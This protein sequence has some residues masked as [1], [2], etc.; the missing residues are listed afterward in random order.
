MGFTRRTF[1]P[2]GKTVLITAAVVPPTGVQVSTFYPSNDGGQAYRIHNNSTVTV[3]VGWG[4]D[5]ATA[6]T[7]AAFPIAGTPSLAVVIPPNDVETFTIGKDQFFS[8]STL[9]STGSVYVVPGSGF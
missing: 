6:Q 5:A 2:E 3:A 1:V 4:V 8:A 7:N 9:A